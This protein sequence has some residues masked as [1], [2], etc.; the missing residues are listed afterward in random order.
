MKRTQRF[1]LWWIIVDCGGLGFDSSKMSNVCFCT[2]YLW[3]PSCEGLVIWLPDK[4]GWWVHFSQINWLLPHLNFFFVLSLSDRY[5]DTGEVEG[6]SWADIARL[7]PVYFYL[8][9]KYQM[10]KR[11][12]AHALTHTKRGRGG[13]GERKRESSTSTEHTS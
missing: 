7:A 5:V 9:V 3:V 11:T 12:L 6:G 2:I 8:L 4:R 13:G 1:V 10:H